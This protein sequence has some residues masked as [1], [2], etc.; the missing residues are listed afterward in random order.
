M[1]AIVLACIGFLFV[2]GAIFYMLVEYV[3]FCFLYA[4]VVVRGILR[5][6]VPLWGVYELIFVMCHVVLVS[7]HFLGSIERLFEGLGNSVLDDFVHVVLH[8]LGN[9]E[10]ATRLRLNMLLFVLDVIYVGILVVVVAMVV[11]YRK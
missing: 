7:C 11:T 2:V 3:T 10:V 5:M 8:L 1:R 4:P 6:F 9:D